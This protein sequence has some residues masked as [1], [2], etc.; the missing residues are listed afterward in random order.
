DEAIGKLS[1]LID[2]RTVPQD[3][4]QV[5]I[6]A[7]GT[8]LVLDSSV[9]TLTA[10]LNGQ[11]QLVVHAANS[12]QTIDIAGGKL[13]GILALVNTT[14]P[15]VRAQFDSLAQALVTQI[16][17]VQASGLGPNGPLTSLTG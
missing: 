17:H 13:G 7:G 8:P 15:S 5:N 3:F 4:G 1:E 16:D 6:L 10:D 14:L 2:V 9:T 12:Q 11:N